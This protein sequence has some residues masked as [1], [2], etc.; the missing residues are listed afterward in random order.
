MVQRF[1]FVFSYWIF[2]WFILYWLGVISYNP[3][4]ALIIGLVD[5]LV[6][7]GIM[8][9]FANSWLN[10]FLF[11]FINFFIKLVPL[12]L[13]RNTP[14]RV[15]DLYAFIGLFGIY[16]LW[17]LV[18][19]VPIIDTAKRR[20]KEIQEDKPLGPFMYYVKQYVYS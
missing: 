14:F 18:N 12:Y 17:I 8:L 5:N 19:E 16:I 9:Y 20:Y 15:R 3:K 11:C 4:I 10:I 13:L 2:A 7:L 6:L 1:D